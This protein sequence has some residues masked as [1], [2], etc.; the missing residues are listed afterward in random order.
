ME[1]FSKTIHGL[2]RLMAEAM[3]DL[4][5]IVLVIAF[6]QVVVIRQPFPDLGEILVGVVLVIMGLA[7]FVK[8]LEMGLFPLGEAMAQAFAR[9]GSALWMMAFAFALGFGTTV[10]EPA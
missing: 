10:A 9:K 6:F 4:A 3:R 1:D 8:G 2:A 7:F 5:P